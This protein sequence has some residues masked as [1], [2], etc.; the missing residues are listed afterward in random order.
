MNP[1]L[2]GLDGPNVLA[3]F[4]EGLPLLWVARYTG[5]RLS[6]VQAWLI[7]RGHHEP[8][9]RQPMTRRA[10]L[11]AAGVPIEGIMERL[12]LSRS[13]VYRGARTTGLRRAPAP[14]GDEERERMVALYAEKRPIL[15]I[16]CAVGRSRRCVVLQLQRAGVYEPARSAATRAGRPADHPWH[17]EDKLW[18][19][20]ARA[21]KARVAGG[22]R[23]SCAPAAPGAPAALATAAADGGRPSAGGGAMGGGAEHRADRAADGL[24]PGRDSAV[25]AR[26]GVVA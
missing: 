2:D 17:R 12:R 7:R 20:R 14:V 6:T 5:R 8:R 26:D 19:M 1:P 4:E 22:G 25:A 18:V 10:A 9:R 11:Y 24:E 13:A 3:L 21:R 15:G 23:A 16:A